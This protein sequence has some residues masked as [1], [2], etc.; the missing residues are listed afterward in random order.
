MSSIADFDRIARCIG[1]ET[2]GVSSR[3]ILLEQGTSDEVLFWKIAIGIF[4][5]DSVFHSAPDRTFFA[6]PRDCDWVT[7]SVASFRQ[8]L[9]RNQKQ[10]SK[11]KQS[12]SVPEPPP[13]PRTKKSKISGQPHK[14]NRGSS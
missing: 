11:L 6:F 5:L 8:T 1:G 3:P 14:F 4:R 9:S 13:P 12:G 7:T 2:I 10:R